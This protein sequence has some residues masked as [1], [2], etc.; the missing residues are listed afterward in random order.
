MPFYIFAWLANLSYS[1]GV[2]SGKLSS[3]HQLSNPWLFNFIWNLLI[4]IFTLPFALAAHVQMPTHWGPLLLLGFFSTLAGTLFI[5]AMYAL[6]VSVL[7][8]MYNLRTAASVVLGVF[9]FHERIAGY[10]IGLIVLML[11]AGLFITMDERLTLKSFFHR[12]I[13]LAII[14]TICSAMFAAAT[15][16]AMKFEGFWEVTL[17][18]NFL[19]FVFIIPTIWFFRDDVRKIQRD[20]WSGV[21][22]HSLFATMGIFAANAAYAINIGISAAIMSAPLTVVLG[23]LFSFFA[24]KLLEK[25]TMKVYAIRFSAA[26]VMII[27]ALQLSR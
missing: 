13:L 22:G 2:V 11:F 18:G 19:T 9:L 4:V 12:S 15:K 6:D 16:Y 27:A 24:P 26:A 10:Q 7:G 17:W 20:Q 1:L 14:T 23:V 25:H 8:P 5:F 3:K 21:V